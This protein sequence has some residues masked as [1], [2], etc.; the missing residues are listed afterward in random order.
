MTPHFL[1]VLC[2]AISFGLKA[3]NIPAKI[4]FL[5]LGLCLLTISLLV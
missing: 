3:A 4:D 2:A 1:L 5:A